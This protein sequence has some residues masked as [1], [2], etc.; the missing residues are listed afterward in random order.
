MFFQ[1]FKNHELSF[2][3]HFFGSTRW[4]WMRPQE[5][6][7]P[8]LD[9]KKLSQELWQ[10]YPRTPLH[11]FFLLTKRRNFSP[12][13]HIIHNFGVPLCSPVVTEH[14]QPWVQRMTT[15]KSCWGKG[16]ALGWHHTDLLGNPSSRRILWGKNSCWPFLGQTICPVL[17]ARNFR[18]Q[19]KMAH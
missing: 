15:Q 2:S 5:V 11:S 3:C 17:L 9:S 14:K 10:V 19:N 6:S 16:V 4:A 12:L 1:S 18:N 8:T 13:L 7:S